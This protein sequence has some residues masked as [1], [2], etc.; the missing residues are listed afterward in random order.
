MT[1]C[2]TTG[3]VYNE[4]DMQGAQRP[5]FLAAGPLGATQAQAG[6][7]G[8]GDGLCSGREGAGP[9]WLAGRGKRREKSR[10]RLLHRSH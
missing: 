8:C 5:L 2:V 3:P 9:G 7:Y 6:P 4:P 1:D 10:N